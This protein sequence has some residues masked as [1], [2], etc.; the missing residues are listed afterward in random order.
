MHILLPN[1]CI[2]NAYILCINIL[3]YLSFILRFIL[4][5]IY[6]GSIFATRDGFRPI[7]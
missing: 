2:Y 1:I 5:L 3:L 6:A 7:G 4:R